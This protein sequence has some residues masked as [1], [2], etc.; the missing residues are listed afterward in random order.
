MG[1]GRSSNGGGSRNNERWGG[2]A[3]GLTKEEGYTYFGPEM[4]VTEVDK[5]M[6]SQKWEDGLTDDEKEALSDYASASGA[7]RILNEELREGRSTTS[8]SPYA[9]QL[10]ERLEGALD[11]YYLRENIVVHRNGGMSLL[12]GANTPEKIKKLY[13]KEVSDLGFTS[14]ATRDNLG[15]NFKATLVSYHIKVPQGMGIGAYIKHHSDHGEKETEF[16]FNRGSVFRVVGSY[17][18]ADG[19]IHVNME[20]A[21]RR[22]R[23]HGKTVFNTTDQYS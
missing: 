12:G 4:D 19:R 23:E 6:T 18:G 16:L 3:S 2:G 14:S 22:V 20:Y 9:K 10:T 17:T 5:H 21:G 7:H 1:T 11:R 15:G 13:G 8:L